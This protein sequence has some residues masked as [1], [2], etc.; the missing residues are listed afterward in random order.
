MRDESLHTR[1]MQGESQRRW[2]MDDF[3]EL[4]VWL[5]ESQAIIG[6]QLVYNK[7]RSPHALTWCQDVGYGHYKVDDGENRPGMPKAAPILLPDSLF[8]PQGIGEAF[9]HASA[10]MDTT[11][12]QFVRQKI[13]AYSWPNQSQVAAQKA[14]YYQEY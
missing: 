5:S 13:V 2:F 10:H 14:L 7:R 3:F 1:Q 9:A 12:A 4:I 8:E 11:M 6:F